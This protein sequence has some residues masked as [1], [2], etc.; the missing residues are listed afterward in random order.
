MPHGL[1]AL[2]SSTADKDL[3]AIGVRKGD[4]FIHMR[5]KSDHGLMVGEEIQLDDDT[6]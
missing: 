5:A 2:E 1:L 4:Q 3:P 6:T